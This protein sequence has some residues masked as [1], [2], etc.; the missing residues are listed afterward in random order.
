MPTDRPLHAANRVRYVEGDALRSE[1]WSAL[2]ALKARETEPPFNVVLSDGL[3]QPHA[4]LAE[5]RALLDHGLVGS[6]ASS[7]K[8]QVDEAVAAPQGLPGGLRS[9][10]CSSPQLC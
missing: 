5:M 7:T 9:S 1:A 2:A 8:A 6:K 3:H 10:P 4:L